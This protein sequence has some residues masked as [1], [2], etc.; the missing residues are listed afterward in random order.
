MMGF[1]FRLITDMWRC[2]KRYA[3]CK[4]EDE[5]SQ[6]IGDFGYIAETYISFGIP[7][8]TEKF[9]TQIAIALLDEIGH[10]LNENLAGRG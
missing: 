6:A 3:D 8:H 10:N 9:V 5:Y 1:Y 4:T 7:K 2:F